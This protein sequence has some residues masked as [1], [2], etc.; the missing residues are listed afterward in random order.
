MTAVLWCNDTDQQCNFDM[1]GSD[2]VCVVAKRSFQHS[3]QSVSL[4]T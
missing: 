4:G 2:A 1:V 3:L